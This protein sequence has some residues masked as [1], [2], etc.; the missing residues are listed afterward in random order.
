MYAHLNDFADRLNQWVKDKQY[1]DEQWEHD[2]HFSKDQFPV[3]KGQFIAYSGNTGASQGP[4]LHFEIRNT[5]TDK[6]INPL[7]FGFGVRDNI[8]PPV[9]R[10]Y[11]YDRNYST[12]S[13]APSEIKIKGTKGRYSARDT[14]VRSGSG[15]ISF[16]IS[17]EDI[18]NGSTFRFG[19]YSAELWLDSIRYYGFKLDELH[20]A[21]RRYMN[22]SIDYVK[23]IRD[24]RT[25]QHLSRLPGNRLDIFEGTNNGVV[26]LTDTLPH[27]LLI[28]VRDVAGNESRLQFKLQW[29]PALQ[30]DLLFTQHT[31]TL[32]PNKVGRVDAGGIA[33]DF[34]DNTFYDTVRFVYSSRV[35]GGG[36][37]LIHQF[38]NTTIPVHE[39]FQVTVIPGAPIDTAKAVMVFTGYR[40][41]EVIKPVVTDGMKFSTNLDGL[42][43][44]T[45][46]TDSEPP[47]I[48]T[49]KWNSGSTFARTG[50]IRIAVSDN[51]GGI[52]VFR[53][54]LDGKW[55]RFSKSGNVFTYKIDEHCG[56]GNHELKITVKDTAGN[57]TTKTFSL[58]V[59]EKLPVKK[60]TVKKRTTKKK[61]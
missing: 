49:Y 42:G 17:A 53:A 13:A 6:N 25:I 33:I 26:E 27:R 30:K 43:S 61:R 59:K 20:Y 15:K 29:K 35:A 40:S 10:L 12:Y 2:I 58:E 7:F 44:I 22:A 37:A 36:V 41:R 56:L 51:V 23:K 16:G 34:S 5:Q 57:E 39:N 24:N 18:V 60:K 55:L 52:T 1:Q 48:Q 45:M 8:A 19:I 9:Y 28:L 38:H 46:L 54:E 11:M 32:E 21:E 47:V 14:L 4:H 31:V 3:V 50:S